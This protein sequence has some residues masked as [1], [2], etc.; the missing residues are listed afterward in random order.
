MNRLV[1]QIAI[2]GGIMLVV[3][4]VALMLAMGTLTHG[5]KTGGHTTTMSPDAPGGVLKAHAYDPPRELADLALTDQDGNPFQLGETGGKVRVIYIG[6]TNCPDVCP[7]TMVNWKTVKK[8]LGP[9]ADQVSFVMVTADPDHDTPEVLKNFVRA[10]DQS[11]IG[12]SGSKAELTPVWDQFGARISRQELPDS[13]AGYSVTHP[14]SMFVLA[15]DGR[16]TLKI[17]YGR[18]PA[19]ITEDLR[20][21]L[22]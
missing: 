1:L 10:F 22:Q 20:G 2:G 19:E 5:S 17:P 14:S 18:T 21:L 11:F 7:M 15:K 3:L 8:T 6:Y 9:L 16:L 12:L 13:A 4:V